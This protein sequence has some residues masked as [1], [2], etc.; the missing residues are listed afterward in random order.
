M[1]HRLMCVATWRLSQKFQKLGAEQSL[2]IQRFLFSSELIWIHPPHLDHVATGIGIVPE[3]KGS[4]PSE[5]ATCTAAHLQKEYKKVLG[6]ASAP[7]IGHLLAGQY[8]LM[9]E[10]PDVITLQTCESYTSV[11]PNGPNPHNSGTLQHCRLGVSP[12]TSPILKVKKKDRRK[13]D[14]KKESKRIKIELLCSG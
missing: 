8:D 14:D 2:H 10:K 4:I 3:E 9:S 7:E 1:F 12:G 5:R 11:H 6:I 13:I